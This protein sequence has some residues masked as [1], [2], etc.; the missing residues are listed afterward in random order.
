MLIQ[1]NP[2]IRGFDIPGIA[3]KLAINLFA[4]NTILYA[5]EWDSFDD[6]QKT[7][8]LQYGAK[9]QEQSLTMTRQK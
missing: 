3:E 7:L 4:D 5:S 2:R 6:I 9:C 1:N 8:D